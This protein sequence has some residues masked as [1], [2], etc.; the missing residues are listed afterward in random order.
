MYSTRVACTFCVQAWV[1][2]GVVARCRRK[3]HGPQSVGVW[4]GGV[5]KFNFE[6]VLRGFRGGNAAVEVKNNFR[7]SIF[8]I[9]IEGRD[10]H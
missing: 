1:R 4:G 3:T 8:I 9:Q 7:F 5:R 10:E 2:V 6:R